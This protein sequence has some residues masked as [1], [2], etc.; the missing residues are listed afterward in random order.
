M[1]YISCID[2]LNF[3]KT[4]I[5]T[6]GRRNNANAAHLAGVRD[7]ARVVPAVQR[8]LLRGAHGLPLHVRQPDP[9][10]RAGDRRPKLPNAAGRDAPTRG[11]RGGAPLPNNRQ[12]D[13]KKL[14]TRR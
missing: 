14:W 9:S 7:D 5:I 4:L 6:L 3:I 2:K 8:V 13:G 12:P 1:K 10:Q 11:G